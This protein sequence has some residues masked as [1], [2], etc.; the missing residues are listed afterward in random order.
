MLNGPEF[1]I[2]DETGLK[3]LSLVSA[4]KE[5]INQEIS[6]QNESSPTKLAILSNSLWYREGYQ[7]AK[8]IANKAFDRYQTET[9]LL[10]PNNQQDNEYQ[11]TTIIKIMVLTDTLNYDVFFEENNFPNYPDKYIGTFKE[12]CISKKNI[13]LLIR[14]RTVLANNSPHAVSF[15]LAAIRI[16]IIEEA[17]I[18]SRPEYSLFTSQKLSSFLDVFHQKEYSKAQAYSHNPKAIFSIKVDGSTSYHHW[19]FSSLCI[20]LRASSEFSWLP[21]QAK[22]D[23]AN[24]SDHFNLLNKLA[25]AAAEK[26]ASDDFL[27]FDFM[28]S[29]FPKEGVLNQV[30]WQER[31]AEKLLKNTWIEISSDCHL[32]TTTSQIS[33]QSLNSVLDL[34]L[35][36]TTQLRTWYKEQGLNLL[37]DDAVAHLIKMEL[38]RQATE[39]EETIEYSSQNLELTEIAYRHNDE[40]LFLKCLR[41]AWDF[42]LGYG[43]RADRTIFNVLNAI[44]HLSHTLPDE[45]FALLEKISPIIANI[46]DFTDG[47]ETSYAKEPFL[48]LLSRLSPQTTAS[49]YNQKLNDGD[50]SY[51]ENAIFSLIERSDFSSPIVN[52]LYLTGLHRSCYSLLQKKIDSGDKHAIEIA[53]RVENL[54][55]INLDSILKED[56]PSKRRSSDR[57]FREANIDHSKYPPN[58]VNDL[59]EAL[60]EKQSSRNLWKAWYLFW[61]QK[62]LDSELLDNL[63]PIV[64]NLSNTWDTPC[65]LDCL[66]ESQKKING[67]TEAFKLL[68]AAHK[69][70]DGWLDDPFSDGNSINRLTILA[71]TYPDR[72]NDFINLTTKQ[73]NSWDDKFG[74]LI[75]PNDKLVYLLT[76]NNRPNEALNLA[77]AM[78]N[79]L[80]HS[81]ENLSLEKPKWDWRRDDSIEEALAKALVSR[82][83]LPVPA[84]KLWTTEQITILLANENRHIENLVIHDLSS[85]A[86]ESEC[87]EVL[88]LFLIAKDRGYSPPGDLGK[89]VNAR[90]ILSDIILKDLDVDINNLGSYKTDFTKSL[91]LKF[92]E[93]SFNYFHGKHFPPCYDSSLRKAEKDTEIPFPSFFRSEWNNTVEYCPI[94]ETDFRHFQHIQKSTGQFYTQ[95]GHRGR[96]AFLRLLR[97]EDAFMECQNMMA[98]N[99]QY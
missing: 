12:A 6:L 47:K 5:A 11:V 89:H 4:S 16:S 55:G 84:I 2:W 61:S 76:K 81:L 71:E 52:H 18:T 36:E 23:G 53:Q 85:R 38:N 67:K 21:V 80:L 29:L 60:K 54:L 70:T 91:N 62:G 44:K 57:G 30:A 42:V 27:P 65:L 24:V 72:V 49:I 68:V 46:L 48:L 14:A 94:S 79:E 8:S 39:L 22:I 66:F 34:E 3:T 17:D 1:Q 25:D 92:S 73:P 63:L 15:E 50:W 95:A 64:D 19:F 31:N 10:N 33:L 59:I 93:N 41:R 75:I 43:H 32:L 56:S 28:C 78:V 86:Q 40:T 98:K 35:F 87:I 51:S 45:A 90:S 88:S 58:K 77:N 26:L 99:Y 20:K 83:K 37:T 9:N 69:A 97:L 82:L 74:N 13:D 96:S 7:Q